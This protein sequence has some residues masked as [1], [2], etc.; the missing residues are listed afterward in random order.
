ME[1]Q[2]ERE[3]V[4][5]LRYVL[6]DG[7]CEAV[8]SRYRVGSAIVEAEERFEGAPAAAEALSFTWPYPVDDGRDRSQVRTGAARFRVRLGRSTQE[9]GTEDGSLELHP[10]TVAHR[11][12]YAGI[13][14]W[15]LRGQSV[16][17]VLTYSGAPW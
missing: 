2:D 8:T 12:G 9:V 4:L 1:R 13:A 6:Q 16:R 11:H 5:S 3:V 14:R 10:G 17:W 7:G 15:R